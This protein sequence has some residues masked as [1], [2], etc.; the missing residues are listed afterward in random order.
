[1][2]KRFLAHRQESDDTLKIRV[3]W[4]GY[5]SAH[6]TWEPVHNLST[7]VPDLVQAYLR[8]YRRDKECVCMLKRYF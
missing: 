2:V 8:L 7:D 5:D 3:W 4:L 1:M 6:D